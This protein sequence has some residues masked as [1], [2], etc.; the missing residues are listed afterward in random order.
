MIWHRK[1][2]PWGLW[3]CGNAS[4]WQWR[5]RTPPLSTPRHRAVC[6]T[7]QLPRS[8]LQCPGG[9][10]R[11]D[12]STADNGY[13]YSVLQVHAAWIRRLRFL[14]TSTQPGCTVP[15]P[16][17]FLRV[18]HSLVV[19]L[20]RLPTC[21]QKLLELSLCSACSS[22]SWE[23]P[24]PIVPPSV[25]CLLGGVSFKSAYAHFVSLISNENAA[26]FITHG[27]LARSGL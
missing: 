4:T 27:F 8:T 21:G 16:I 17:A 20:R 26:E 10:R 12:L 1:V 3:L 19:A 18:P 24:A 2:P 23:G 5:A 15:G 22:P 9:R 11:T 6:R 7:C 14:G 13:S 25:T